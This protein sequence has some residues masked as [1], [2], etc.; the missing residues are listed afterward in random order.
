MN[1]GKI[2]KTGGK[3]YIDNC[4]CGHAEFEIRFSVNATS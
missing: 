2:Y 3:S 4:F 1:A